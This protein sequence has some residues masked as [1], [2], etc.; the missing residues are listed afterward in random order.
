MKQ[1][2]YQIVTTYLVKN[3]EMFYRLAYSYTREKEGALD[4][5]QNAMLKALEHYKDLRNIEFLKTWFYKILVNESLSY[6]RKKGKEIL[7]LTEEMPEQTYLEANYQKDDSLYDSIQRLP[8]SLQTII[9]L[10]YYNGFTLK[11]IAEITNTNQNT[12]KT[13]LYSAIKKLK[14]DLEEQSYE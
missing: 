1:S 9:K 7:T 14:I 12:V 6:L 4:I 11:E 5:V 2:N 13:R 8:F 3:Q 10:H